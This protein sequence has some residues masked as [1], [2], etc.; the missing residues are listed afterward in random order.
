MKEDTEPLDAEIETGR[1]LKR[2][3]DEAGAIRHFE[4]LS[5]HYPD[6]PRVIAELAYAYDFAGR[7]EQ[8]VAPYRRA[9]E[10]GLPEEML[11]GHLLGLGSTLRNV[12]QVE[13][14]VRILRQA[15]A[16]FPERADL[17][18]FLALS[19]H[20]AGE[21]TSAL[22]TLL[23]LILASPGVDLHGYERAARYYTDELAGRL[24]PE[25]T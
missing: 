3:G 21:T 9:L 14:S 8:A 1:A 24:A 19:L 16:R 23:D 6:H 5:M 25:E 20:S 15:V 17:R 4:A 13:E 11:P 7:E 10:L 2:S 18:V 12:G 22:V